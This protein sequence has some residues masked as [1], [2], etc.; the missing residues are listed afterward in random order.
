MVM[1]RVFISFDFDNDADLRGNLV[2]QSERRDSPF[3]IQD[4]SLQAPYDE[5]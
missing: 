3:S 4:C 1:K 5:K 2:A